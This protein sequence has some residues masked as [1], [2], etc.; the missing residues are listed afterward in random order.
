MFYNKQALPRETTSFKTPVPHVY[1]GGDR[2]LDP[3]RSCYFSHIKSHSFT[4]QISFVHN[5]QNLVQMFQNVVFRNIVVVCKTCAEHCS[6]PSQYF[7]R[8]LSECCC[9][10]HVCTAFVLVL[11]KHPSLVCWILTGK[12]LFT[13]VMAQFKTLHAV[14]QSLENSNF[15]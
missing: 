8:S 10:K 6:K 15:D 5:V 3:L 7:E 2:P 11:F 14:K 1:Q 12:S 9:Q 4:S 13:L